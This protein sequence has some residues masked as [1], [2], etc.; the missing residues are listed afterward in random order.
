VHAWGSLLFYTSTYTQLFRSLGVIGDPFGDGE[1]QLLAPF[2]GV[3]IGH[4]QCPLVHE[5]DAA[6]N[7]ARIADSADAAARIDA[8]TSDLDERSEEHTS[9][10]QSRENL[11]CRLL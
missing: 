3:V 8:L 7:V 2:G 1:S 4:N 5:G 11:V 6:F 9:E 10:L